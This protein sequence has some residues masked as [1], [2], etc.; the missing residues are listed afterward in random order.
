MGVA[1]G[2]GVLLAVDVGVRVCV[3]V[4]VSVM[5]APP[6]HAALGTKMQPPRH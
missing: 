2:V 5:H 6:K 1:V 4:G 3:G